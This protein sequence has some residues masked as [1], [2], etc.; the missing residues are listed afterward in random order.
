MA[1]TRLEI[2]RFLLYKLSTRGHQIPTPQS[3][4]FLFI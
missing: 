3:H 4:Q 1:A 2:A